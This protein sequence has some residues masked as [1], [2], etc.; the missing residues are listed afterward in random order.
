VRGDVSDTTHRGADT[1]QPQR[2]ASLE[3]QDEFTPIRSAAQACTCGKLIRRVMFEAEPIA[4]RRQGVV[5]GVVTKPA[6]G[7][8][9]L[10]RAS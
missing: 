8:D 2:H 3:F 7:R 5:R 9:H 6:G 10:L 4:V 1:A